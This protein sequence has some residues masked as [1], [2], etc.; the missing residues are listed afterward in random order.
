MIRYRYESLA[1]SLSDLQNHVP[2][3]PTLEVI[4][5]PLTIDVTVDPSSK[6]D[7]DDYLTNRGWRFI[8]EVNYP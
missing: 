5:V 6:Q 2:G 7:L 4:S 8:G 1:M 3:L